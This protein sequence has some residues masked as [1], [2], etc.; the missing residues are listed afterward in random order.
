MPLFTRTAISLTSGTRNRSRPPPRPPSPTPTPPLSSTSH[1]STTSSSGPST[2]P[3]TDLDPDSRASEPWS[4]VSDDPLQLGDHH[5]HHH[6]DSLAPRSGLGH[7]LRSTRSRSKSRSRDDGNERPGRVGRFFRRIASHKSLRGRGGSVGDEEGQ[8]QDIDGEVDKVPSVPSLPPRLEL[9]ELPSLGAAFELCG[10]APPPPP[11]P[12]ARTTASD[13]V[14]KGDLASLAQLVDAAADSVTSPSPSPPPPSSSSAALSLA[15]EPAPPPEPA[16]TPPTLAPFSRLKKRLSRLALPSSTTSTSAPLS[17]SLDDGAESLDAYGEASDE[18]EDEGAPTG[19]HAW[20]SAPAPAPTPSGA[21]PAARAGAPFTTPPTSP[22]YGASPPSPH[23]PLSPPPPRSPF[24]ARDYDPNVERLYAHARA[25]LAAPP[26]PAL[27]LASA[28]TTTTALGPPFA[29][30]LPGPASTHPLAL[31]LPSTA[32]SLTAASSRPR[33]RR[34]HALRTLLAHHTLRAKLLRGVTLVD[35]AELARTSTSTSTSPAPLLLPLT[36]LAIAPLPLGPATPM[37]MPLPRLREWAARPGFAERAVV[38]TAGG[39]TDVVRA[40]VRVGGEGW[41]SR[42]M[43][44][45][46]DVM[47]A[48]GVPG[49]EEQEWRRGLEREGEGGG[50]GA[51]PAR[52]APPRSHARGPSPSPVGA[53]LVGAAPVLVGDYDSRPLPAPPVRAPLGPSPGP[54][55]LRQLARQDAEARLTGSRAVAEEEQRVAEEDEDEDEDERP[56]ATLPR[57]PQ[58][59]SRLVPLPPA[60]LGPPL[61]LPPSLTS[62]S[63]TPTPSPSPSSTDLDLL[64]AAQRK[65]ARLEAELGRLRAREACR[66]KEEESA[67]RERERV[68]KGE[69]RVRRRAEEQRRRT[70]VMAG[71]AS[72]E[73]RRRS[74]TPTPGPSS[75]LPHPHPHSHSHSCGASY[76]AVPPHG[77]VGL[78]WGAT[79]TALGPPLYHQ[80]LHALSAPDLQALQRQQALGCSRVA[81]Q[82][83]QR[84]SLAPPSPSGPPPPRPQRNSLRPPPHPLAHPL[85]HPHALPHSRST[86][87]IALSPPS[88][89]RSPFLAP[90]PSPSAALEPPRRLAGPGRRASYRPPAPLVALEAA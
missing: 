13:D 22:L 41:R 49:G 86:P 71:P 30:V 14:E 3:A 87:N 58:R 12:P 11:P 16:P 17:L 77:H 79:A 1:T 67:A 29:H 44:A 68:G 28:T 83:Q 7:K 69:E 76:L 34:T 38:H 59:A 5:H 72:A 15:S 8:A 74:T 18:D 63:T 84:H 27:A 2:P 31:F 26:G 48:G 4:I 6:L 36:P 82:Q 60:A 78:A 81:P 65:T 37:P 55:L 52:E 9:L 56:L 73:A 64:A 40:R 19:T 46:L 80:P 32:S 62:R 42:G 53:W 43:G 33:P 88:R 23:S 66:R 39:G 24:L 90:P 21:R 10:P 75:A 50:R 57:S 20:L 25:R 54:L 47:G 45:W 89:A 61:H 35:R 70:R 51:R 85:A